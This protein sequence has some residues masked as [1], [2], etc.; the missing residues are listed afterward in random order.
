MERTPVT[1]Q[2][3]LYLVSYVTAGLILAVGVVSLAGYMLPAYVPANYRMILGIVMIIYGA[4]RI[5]TVRMKQQHE[6]RDRE[7]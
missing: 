1:A 3:I 5:S 6:K 2:T 4:Y 7:N